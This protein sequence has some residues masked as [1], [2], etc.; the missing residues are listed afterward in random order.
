[1]GEDARA[2]ASFSRFLR[3]RTDH[4]SPDYS[5]VPALLQEYASAAGFAL[6]REELVAG[7]PL[8]IVTWAGSEPAAP[9]LVLMCHMDVVP[10]D[11]G[12]WTQDPWGGAVVDG[13][14]YGRGA[15]DMKCVG[16]QYLEACSRLR[17][18]GAQPLRTVH[19]LFV[20]DEE[21]GGSRGIKPLLSSALWREA[22][23]PGFLLDEGL[24]SPSPAFSLFYGERKIWWVRL[25]ATGPAGHG[26]RFVPHTAVAQLQAVLARIHAFHEAQRAELAK[27]CA[28]GKQLGDFTTANVT[29]L[30]AGCADA[31]KP[32]YNVIPTEAL[33]GVDIRIPASTRLEDFRRV[34]DGWCDVEGGGVTWE[35][36]S[37][38]CG[39]G[40]LMMSNPTTPVE[41][42]DA[43]WYGVFS[44]AMSAAGYAVNAPS[45][46]PAATDS[47]WVRLMSGVPCL[48]FSPMRNTPI[49][50]HDHDEYLSV[51][52][53]LEGVRVYEALLPALFNDA[54]FRTA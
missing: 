21:V 27:G 7:H 54:S 32:Q 8:F 26:S 5:A 9:A 39:E 52:S 37:Q 28:C 43:H 34:L 4:P 1:M 45:I 20:P 49:L 10:V 16:I 3:M 53:F 46:F 31:A 25:R 23:N 13:R 18:A 42:P 40:P 50:L 11:A 48:G 12:K 33:A 17:A 24:A 19:M 22:L 41:G 36:L 47:R 51:D 35:P 30:S 44:R 14:V 6:R 15:Q 38:V 29:M 2:V